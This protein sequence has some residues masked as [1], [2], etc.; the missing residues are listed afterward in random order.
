MVSVVG[1]GLYFT[2]D[3][4]ITV[5]THQDRRFWALR[6]LYRL[7]SDVNW[8]RVG[9]VIVPHC[10]CNGTSSFKSS[11]KCQ[12]QYTGYREYGILCSRTSLTLLRFCFG[13]WPYVTYDNLRSTT[14]VKPINIVH[15]LAASFILIKQ[16]LFV[17]S[18]YTCDTHI[19]GKI[20]SFMRG[21]SSLH[22]VC[23]WLNK[24]LVLE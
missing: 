15:N 24:L 11:Q 3:D 21:A 12:T 19:N 9:F 1:R 13:K 7:S 20:T 8:A 4:E 14:V 22:V 6:S 10:T 16:K 23:V 5:Q 18:I 2:P 17:Y